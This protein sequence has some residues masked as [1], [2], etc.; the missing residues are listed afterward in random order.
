M[1]CW[2]EVKHLQLQKKE[3]SPIVEMTF[4]CFHPEHCKVLHS[5]VIEM[6][7]YAQA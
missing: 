1:S 6:L 5:P 7:R 4:C 2:N 3:I